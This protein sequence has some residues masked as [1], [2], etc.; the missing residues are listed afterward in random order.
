MKSASV[1][2]N[3]KFE[4]RKVPFGLAQAPTYIQQLISELLKC[5]NFS[6]GYLDNIL[7]FSENNKKNGLKIQGLYLLD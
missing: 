5:L 1:T 7:A 2:P 4:F 6:F 3:S